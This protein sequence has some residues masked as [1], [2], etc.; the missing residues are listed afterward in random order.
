MGRIQFPVNNRP[1]S[2]GFENE[3][4]LVSTISSRGCCHFRQL[5][6][7][8]HHLRRRLHIFIA[9]F[10]FRFC[11]SACLSLSLSFFHSL[12]LL[13]CVS[14]PPLFFS[15]HF[16]NVLPLRQTIPGGKVRLTIYTVRN[17]KQLGRSMIS[18]HPPTTFPLS[19]ELC[20]SRPDVIDRSIAAAVAIPAPSSGLRQCCRTLALDGLR[21]DRDCRPEGLRNNQRIHSSVRRSGRVLFTAKSSLGLFTLRSAA[22]SPQLN[23]S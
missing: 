14:F 18:S 3:G 17:N 13:L 19:P 1:A 12:R 20:L 23:R 15:L 16:E 5:H 7:D 6:R 22:A 8:R 4:V 2:F 21:L 9:Y 11:F 10:P